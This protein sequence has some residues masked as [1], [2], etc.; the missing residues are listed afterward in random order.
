[1]NLLRILVPA[2]AA[3]LFAAAYRAWG[4]QGVALAA[5]A[6]VMWALLHFTRVLHVLRRTADQPIGHVGS[7]VMLNAR[8][9]PGMRLLHVVAMTRSLGALCSAA[10]AQPEVYRWS[11]GTQS[12]V[13]AAFA[14]GRLLR[15]ELARPA[16]DSPAP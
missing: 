3:V 16:Q 7:A 6:A 8:L 15:W 12:H 4:W 13:T 9:R 2:G 1:M 14:N 11:D 5:G 10:G